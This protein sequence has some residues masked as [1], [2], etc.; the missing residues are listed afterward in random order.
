MTQAEQA[1]GASS[2]FTHA[3]LWG[4]SRTFRLE[5]PALPVCCVDLQRNDRESMSGLVRLLRSTGLQLESGVV[6]GLNLRACA[7][8]EAMLTCNVMHVPRLVAPGTM[9]SGSL[10]VDFGTIRDGLRAHTEQREAQ[11]E[12]ESLGRAYDLL[13]KL[14]Q[15]YT[16]EALR[17]MGERAPP[18]W[19][20]KL[21]QPWMINQPDAETAVEVSDVVAAHADLWAE[22]RL[23]EACGVRLADALL[24]AVPY[25]SLI[26]I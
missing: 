6:R 8:P 15:R 26:H 12:M 25:L 13:E 2:G 24:G 16:R 20:H 18:L 5:A 9:A 23:G 21:L 10:T 14:C 4:L 22:A 7:E 3:G 11:L 17:E 1:H 19:H